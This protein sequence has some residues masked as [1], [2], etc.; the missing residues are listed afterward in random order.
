MEAITQDDDYR[1]LDD[2]FK[3]I[4]WGKVDYR[5]GQGPLPEVLDDL[6]WV[7][8]GIHRMNPEG[9]AIIEA[10]ADK[11]WKGTA[12]RKLVPVLFP[13][14]SK[15]REVVPAW[16][17]SAATAAKLEGNEWMAYN[18]SLYHVQPNDIIFFPSKEAAAGFAS[19]NVSDVD[20]YAVRPIADMDSERR[21]NFLSFENFKVM[22]QENFDYLKDNIKYMGFGEKL[23]ESLEEHIK[24]QNDSFQL[25]FKAEVNK[26]PFEATLHFRK[27]DSSGKYFFNSYQAKLERSNGQQV[28]QLFYLN[29]GKGVTAKEAYNLLEGRAVYKEL[30]NKEGETYKAW[31]QLDFEKKD[32]HENHEVKQFHDNYGYDVK[33]AVSKYA[34]AELDG[35]DKEKALLQSLQKGN[36]QSITIEKEHGT[37]KMFMEANPQYKSVHLY[38]GQMKRVQKE[39][40]DLYKAEGKDVKQDQKKS[41]NQKVKVDGE[42]VKKKAAKKAVSH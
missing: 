32:K 9:Q 18:G 23:H 3:G 41:V 17:V 16:L 6:I 19:D 22:D 28:D 27:S 35:G 36:V 21:N 5:P 39:S 12:I 26:K 2:C 11:Y 29:K 14:A 1:Y 38:D 7:A 10:L 33:A 42:P 40:L 8:Q 4:D 13:E 31:I 30:S 37:Y 25:H 24:K 34:V 20:H 15:V